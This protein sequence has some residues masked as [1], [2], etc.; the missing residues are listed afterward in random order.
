MQILHLIFIVVFSLA[1]LAWSIFIISK[2]LKPNHFTKTQKWIHIILVILIPIVWGVI[3]LSILKPSYKGT[4]SPE[5]M[6]NK[7]KTKYENNHNGVF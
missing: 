4:S 1:Y 5:Y 2:I 6:I 7:Q 3:L